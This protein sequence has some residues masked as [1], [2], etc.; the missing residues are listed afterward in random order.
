MGLKA[1]GVSLSSFAAKIVSAGST[2]I[3]ILLA[4]HW[5]SFLPILQNK[6]YTLGI[7]LYCNAKIF[8]F[9]LQTETF[10]Y[11]IIIFNWTLFYG[12]DPIHTELLLS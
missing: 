8:C 3:I 5:V 10:I 6:N 12:K 1:N 11:K 4:S 2:S 7:F 9:L